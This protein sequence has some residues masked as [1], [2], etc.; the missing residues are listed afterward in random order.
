MTRA[1]SA[2]TIPTKHRQTQANVMNASREQHLTWP[3]CVPAQKV[4]HYFIFVSAV[5]LFRLILFFFVTPLS[6]SYFCLASLPLSARPPL[7]LLVLFLFFVTPLSRFYFC[8]A[9][10]PL[11]ARAPLILLLLFLFFVTPH[12]RFP[13]FLSVS[14]SAYQHSYF[15]LFSS[16]CRLF[17]SMN[18]HNPLANNF[19]TQLF[20]F[21]YFFYLKTTAIFHSHLR[22]FYIS[23]SFFLFLFFCLFQLL[24][25]NK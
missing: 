4:I 15:S 24:I 1:I 19:T 6:R 18:M 8:L 14:L 3:T 7:I 13:C 17:P 20:I 23:L 9:S 25:Y 22:F 5:S 11:S 21:F 2:V 16:F 10:L 12:S